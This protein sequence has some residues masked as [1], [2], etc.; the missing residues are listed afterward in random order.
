MAFMAQI[1]LAGAAILL[2]TIAA[3]AAWCVFETL[4]EHI[5]EWRQRRLARIEAELDAKAERTRRVI[6]RLAEDLAASRDE[7]SQAMARA[8]FLATGDS[9][10]MGR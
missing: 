8:M 7:A 3:V 4:Y 2:V 1:A 5:T 6:L 9:E 10:Q